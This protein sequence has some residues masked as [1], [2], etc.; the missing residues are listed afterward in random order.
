M[1]VKYNKTIIHVQY[2]EIIIITTTIDESITCLE[3][4]YFLLPKAC[5][6]NDTLFRLCIIEKSKEVNNI[7][8]K[9]KV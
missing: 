1:L 4:K 5:Y 6:T 9:K 8:N 3:L 2:F 7:Q